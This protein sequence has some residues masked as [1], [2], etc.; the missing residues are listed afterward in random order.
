VSC[1]EPASHFTASEFTCTSQAFD[2]EVSTR[3][4]E[5]GCVLDRWQQM[6]SRAAR[7]LRNALFRSVTHPLPSPR[8]TGQR[9]QR[10]QSGDEP[11]LT[12][13][14]LRRPAN[15]HRVPVIM[16]VGSASLS[17]GS[18]PNLW[19]RGT[20]SCKRA[21]QR[22]KQTGASPSDKRD[23]RGST[24]T[25]MHRT[26]ARARS[27]HRCFVFAT[28]VPLAQAP[29]RGRSSVVSVRLDRS[30]PA[31]VSWCFDRPPHFLPPCSCVI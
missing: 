30:L 6:S 27:S 1:S 16:Q 13:K 12:E 26:H 7:T 22:E 31:G 5:I 23:T 28:P 3:S 19:P 14:A 21:E 11:S 18:K 29:F 24:R 2:N 10:A 20:V 8:P 4:N 17:N 25:D 9:R 15:A